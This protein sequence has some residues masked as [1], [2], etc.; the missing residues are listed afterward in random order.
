M[1][2]ISDLPAA[3]ALDGSETIPLVQDGQSRQVPVSTL[4]PGGVLRPGAWVRVN[5]WPR[6]F[7]GG[8]GTVSFDVKMADGSVSALDEV[9]T[10][11]S[12]DPLFPYFGASAV[13]V[14]ATFT[15]T[16]TAEIL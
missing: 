1:A 8:A 16:A 4:V 15:G 10:A 12:S 3:S 7:V 5:G 9:F 13:A 6:L 2:R 14:R 11:P